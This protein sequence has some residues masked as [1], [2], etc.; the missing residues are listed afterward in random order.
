[1]NL[2]LIVSHLNDEVAKYTQQLSARNTTY[3]LVP[4]IKSYF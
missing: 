3:M 1:M 4:P 2:R